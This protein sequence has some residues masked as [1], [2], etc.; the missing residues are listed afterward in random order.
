M[1]RETQRA[2]ALLLAGVV[3]TGI[4]L[5]ATV[6]P[7]EI[8]QPGTQPGE[9]GNLESPDK[10]DNCHGTYDRTV[11]PAFNW[12]GSLMGNAGRDPIFWATLAIAEQDF[13]GSGDLCIRCHSTGGWYAGRSTPTDGSG[14]AAGDDDGV[15]CDTCHKM[16]NP[17]GSELTGEMT[18]PFVAND[19]TEGWYGS[20][21]LSLWGGGEKLGPYADTSARHRVI[22]SSFHRS[23]DF[24][25]SCHDVSNPAV[26]DLAPENGTQEGADAVTA[27]GVLGGAI[28]G[29]AAFHNAPYRFG[30][31]ERTYSEFRSGAISST[32][33]AD[34]PSLPSELRDGA[35]RAVYESALVAGTGGDYEDGTD[36][37]YTCQSCHMRPVPGAGCNKNG[38]R[39][40]KDL[41]LHDLTGGNHW[42]ADLILYQDAR[43]D[44]RL[45]GGL[46][47]VQKDALVAGVTRAMKQ[48][49]SAATL[50]VSGDTLRIVNHTGHKLIT[51][52]PEGQRMWVQVCWY[53]AAAKLIREDGRYGPLVDGAGDPVTVPDPAGGP[54]VQVRSLLDPDDP[55]TRVYEA[56]Y[57]I[58]REWAQTLLALHP[59]S[60]PVSYD[61]LT[62]LPDCRLGD[63]ASGAFGD[64]HESFHFVLNDVVVEDD[65]IP[66]Y[67]F[68]YA[69]AR[70]RNALPVPED[71]Y[72]Y[73]NAD[74]VYR[75]WDEL[76]LDPPDGAVYAE[77]GLQYQGTS[78][79]YVQFL[80]KANDGVARNAFLGEEGEHFL[81]AWL[82]TGMAEPYTM[83]T[84]VWGT[85]PTPATPTIHVSALATWATDRQGRLTTP[86]TSFKTRDTV[87]FVARVV[88]AAQTPVG[89]AQ[90][91]LEIV[92][93]SGAVVSA[94]Q[95]FSDAAGDALLQWKTRHSEASGT[96]T[97]RV[98]SVLQDSYTFDADA[99]V[100][101]VTFTLQ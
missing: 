1:R 61:R 45:G 9:V 70:R 48:L 84:A 80:W 86:A 69:E 25:G 34:Y 78:W 33:V 7:P 2:G 4:A 6:A 96:Y 50:Q 53:D 68:S 101:T 83:A 40:R 100:T 18:A 49:S 71:Q 56:H 73:P 38:A 58:S 3:A 64:R 32:R 99:G 14:L 22:Q 54:D 36:R 8:E 60:L 23:Q 65:R 72:G 93:P 28:E 19:G 42:A 90:V 12:R 27:S 98:V 81:E 10:C 52:Y 31:V 79:E 24:C 85:P 46:T 47:T 76:A 41:P 59:S 29:K 89:G 51:G 39:V 87:A 11:E 16:T 37:Y 43:G 13:D 77:I 17:D 63:L 66:P 55:H 35:L 88:D 15:D 44:L 94:A 5:A 20:G 92:D 57:G 21:M 82:H 97:G 91:F 30:V 74:G 75:H 95:G 67:G 26:G 62:G